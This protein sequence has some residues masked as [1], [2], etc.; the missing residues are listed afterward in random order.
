M[1]PSS[2]DRY[3][4]LWGLQHTQDE[5]HDRS[6]GWKALVKLNMDN[7]F[8]MANPSFPEDA[9]RRLQELASKRS[10][11]T[12]KNT[13]IDE[14]IHWTIEHA[15]GRMPN[16]SLHSRAIPADFGRNVTLFFDN[17]QSIMKEGHPTKAVSQNFWPWFVKMLENI[18]PSV[19]K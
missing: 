15:K 12:N 16:E 19:Q 5:E 7:K 11:G 4:A 8:F 14:L 1:V 13:T 2:V 18:A 10:R 17:M 3:D 6:S 9:S